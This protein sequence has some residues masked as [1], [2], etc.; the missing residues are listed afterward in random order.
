MGLIKS[1]KSPFFSFTE[2]KVGQLEDSFAGKPKSVDFSN[3]R[4][5]F[6]LLGLIVKNGNFFSFVVF[7]LFPQKRISGGNSDYLGIFLRGHNIDIRPG[8]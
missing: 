4:Y 5:D 7:K 3:S 2:D 8:K 1:I 6:G